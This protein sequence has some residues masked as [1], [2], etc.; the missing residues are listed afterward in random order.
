MLHDERHFVRTAEAQIQAL[1]GVDFD[2]L[3][4]DAALRREMDAQLLMISQTA[5][6]VRARG[7]ML[8]AQQSREALSRADELP[9]SLAMLERLIAQYAAGLRE[10]DPEFD[11]GT[12]SRAMVETPAAQSTAPILITKPIEQARRAAAV[13]APLTAMAHDHDQSALAS[14]MA[15]S[16]EQCG[17][18]A[19]L[20][21][22]AAPQSIPPQTDAPQVNIES[23]M[24][25]LTNALLAAAHSRNI[26]ISVSYALDDMDVPKAH[27]GPLLDAL[28]TGGVQM[29]SAIEKR[30]GESG[31][32]TPTLQIELTGRKASQ[33]AGAKKSES[34]ALDMAVPHLNMARL[35][36]EGLV[37]SHDSFDALAGIGGAVALRPISAGGVMLSVNYAARAEGPIDALHGSFDLRDQFEEALA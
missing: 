31:A 23:L 4:C 1:C 20:E 34:F 5:K 28:V 32:I 24:V 13:L 12:A 10:I 33:S 18:A 8:A 2:A 14:L 15:L 25:P 26:P 29:L 6:A 3:E 21:R 17:D 37:Q 19:P 36:P 9:Q 7:V 16:A 35:K 30:S 27:A 11:A 22:R